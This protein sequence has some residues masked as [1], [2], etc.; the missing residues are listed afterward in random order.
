MKVGDVV[1]M[2]YAM[3]WMLKSNRHISYTEDPATV[4]G[5][6]SHIMEVMWADGRIDRR[7]KDLFEVIENETR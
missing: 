3:F 1:R 6:G 7:D 2:K 5:M 4:V